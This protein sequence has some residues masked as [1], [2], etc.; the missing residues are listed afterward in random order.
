MPQPTVA[1]NQV[2]AVV[3]ANNQVSGNNIGYD[4]NAPLTY[5]QNQL[6]NAGY[7]PLNASTAD[8]IYNGLHP[9]SLFS[10]QLTSDSSYGASAYGFGGNAGG[11]PTDASFMP[12]AV[13]G[14]GPN[15]NGEPTNWDPFST[16]VTVSYPS[17]QSIVV[18]VTGHKLTADDLAYLTAMADQNTFAQSLQQQS[19]AA[20]ATYQNLTYNAS[21]GFAAAG[22]HIAGLLSEV[23]NG[24]ANGILNLAT[25]PFNANARAIFTHNAGQTWD[26]LP[27]VIGGAVTGFVNA[28]FSEK[29]DTVFKL[30]AGAALGGGVF[31]TAGVVG[32]AG[33]DGTMAVGKFALSALQDADIATNGLQFAGIPIIPSTAMY[34]VPPGPSLG[35]LADL[36]TA[37][38]GEVAFAAQQLRNTPGIVTVSDELQPASGAWLDASRPT[39]IPAQVGDALVGQTFNSFDDLRSAIWGEI[40][41][42]ADLSGGF[43]RAN[44]AQMMNGNSPFAPSEYL[45]DTGAFGDRFNLHHIDPISEGGSVYD[46]S[47]LQIVSPQTHFD[48]HYGL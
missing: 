44:L 5:P 34:V 20:K 45:A 6:L 19:D 21:N 7:G 39:G 28:P 4:A 3:N 24:T 46:L 32:S 18:Q 35:A 31:K 37:A 10:G 12:A 13:R 25:L 23:G 38:E 8:A 26:N 22:W 29:A 41:S 17:E 9:S 15:L 33:I 11:N 2:Q 43:S 42:N 30:A 36:G 48:I 14:L 1:Q 16:N 27:A 47:N 40:G